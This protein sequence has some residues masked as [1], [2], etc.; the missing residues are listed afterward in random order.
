MTD[1]QLDRSEAAYIVLVAIEQEVA[2]D[3]A[4]RALQGALQGAG[5]RQHLLGRRALA[6]AAIVGPYGIASAT[7]S[8]G[9][10]PEPMATARYCL[11]SWR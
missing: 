9:S 2:A 5:R 4:Q 10:R 6:W 7:I 8:S 3:D 11:P 1:E